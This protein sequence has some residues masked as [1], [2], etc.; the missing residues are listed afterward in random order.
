MRQFFCL[1]CRKQITVNVGSGITPR[2][3]LSWRRRNSKLTT[4]ANHPLNKYAA[5]ALSGRRRNSK[6]TTA[7]NHPLN[8]Y[9]ALPKRRLRN[10]A[11]LSCRGDGGTVNSP[12]RQIISLTNT[13]LFLKRG[14]AF[15][16]GYGGQ[17]GRKYT[18]ADVSA[19]F[20]VKRSFPLPQ[21]PSTLIR[22]GAFLR[23]RVR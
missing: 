1:H 5:F 2:L 21:E 15:A 20:L 8:K 14:S 23:R 9:A 10:H 12:Q 13:S 6:L 16:Q 22:N 4:A 11:V 7:A 17:G 3:A 19:S 18:E